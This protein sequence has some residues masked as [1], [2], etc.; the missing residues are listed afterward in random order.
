MRAHFAKHE[1]EAALTEVRHIAMPDFYWMHVFA[2]AILGQL[3]HSDAKEALKRVYELRPD[4]DA[5]AELERWN[6]APDDMEH[7]LDGLRKAGLDEEASA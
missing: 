3:G 5:L 6:T 2:A 7:I 4:F 1:Y